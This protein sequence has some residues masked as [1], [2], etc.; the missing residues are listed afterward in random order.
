MADYRLRTSDFRLQTS[1]FSLQTD[2]IY[3]RANTNWIDFSRVLSEHKMIH[4]QKKS[5]RIP[6]LLY[7]IAGG[8]RSQ[9]A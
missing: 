1:D 5:L 8:N 7:I 4:E 3:F 9:P 2:F 6:D